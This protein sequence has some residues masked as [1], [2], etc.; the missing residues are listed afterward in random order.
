MKSLF[1]FFVLF[2]CLTLTSK[3]SFAE[4]KSD[5]TTEVELRAFIAD[6]TK[7]DLNWILDTR[8]LAF[9][10]GAINTIT[11][12]DRKL[13]G[14][15]HNLLMPELKDNIDWQQI[16]NIKALLSTESYYPLTWDAYT[17]DSIRE[18]LKELSKQR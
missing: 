13:L 9:E 5:C 1:R 10:E 3:L 14:M 11:T 16:D 2:I 4:E 6:I 15:V 17:T 8:K 18:K 7:D 12:L